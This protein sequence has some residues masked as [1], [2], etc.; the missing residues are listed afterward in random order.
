MVGMET[1]DMTNRHGTVY[2]PG[3]TVVVFPGVCVGLADGGYL[4]VEPD[5]PITIDD[6]EATRVYILPKRF[7]LDA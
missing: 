6:V 4:I 2:F 1:A 3:S 5:Y 7:T